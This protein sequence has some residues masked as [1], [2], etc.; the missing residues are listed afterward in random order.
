M[1]ISNKQEAIDFINT[2]ISS[3]SDNTSNLNPTNGFPIKYTNFS[4]FWKH[5]IDYLFPD[6]QPNFDLHGKSPIFRNTDSVGNYT[7]INNDYSNLTYQEIVPIGGIIM[8]GKAGDNSNSNIDGYLYCDGTKYDITLSQNYK[9]KR[10][11]DII[12]TTFHNPNNPLHGTGPVNNML[13]LPDFR[14]KSPIGYDAAGTTTRVENG[15]GNNTQGIGNMGGRNT[16]TLENNNLPSHN[17]GITKGGGGV[18]W[19]MTATTNI[20][21]MHDH[22]FVNATYMENASV[23]FG[24]S[25]FFPYYTTKSGIS[26]A[27]NSKGSSGT[28][29]DNMPIAFYDKTITGGGFVQ[30][31]S[32][33]SPIYNDGGEHSHGI[34]VTNYTLS[35][36]TNNTGGGQAF[37]NRSAYV[38]T[39]YIIKY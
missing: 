4:S 14:S 16:V 17:H 6:Q 35:G 18:T 8:Y 29:T 13:Y 9:Y 34:N 3:V 5:F 7:E 23:Y 36:N 11:Y 28:D 15:I 25:V 12:G 24:N 20:S 1:S 21:G 2:P 27:N 19:S 33:S 22:W 39:N 26:L 31:A 37:N 30:P 32:T 38:V 10:L